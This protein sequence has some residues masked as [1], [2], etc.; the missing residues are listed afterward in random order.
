MQL[1]IVHQYSWTVKT[2]RLIVQKRCCKC[3]EVVLLQVGTRVR[4]QREARGVR[5]GKAVTGERTDL[6]DDLVLYILTKS[7][8]RHPAPQLRFDF[9]HPFFRALETHGAP[10]IFCLATGKIG[11]HHGYTKEL[12]LKEWHTEGPLQNRLQRGVRVTHRLLALAA[13]H[14]RM[15]HFSDDWPGTNNLHL[16]HSHRVRLAQRLVNRRIVGRKLREIDRLGVVFRDQFEALFQHG[17]HP[18]P[19]QID[20]HDTHVGT[21][22]LVP[23]HDD[24]PRHRRWFERNYGIELS[25]TH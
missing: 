14:V 20:L 6:H 4:N 17:H 11:R 15:H 2:H 3:G 12:L 22:V 18:K 23:L 1:R 9:L 24:P 25:L 13:P 21:I 19:Q 7:V 16:K 10:Q 5:F 8:V